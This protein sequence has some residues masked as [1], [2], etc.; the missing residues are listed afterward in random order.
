M[1][2][3]KSILLL[4]LLIL[5]Q[6]SN[7][8]DLIVYFSNEGF[9]V[10]A[11]ALAC[12]LI[13]A[14]KLN[15]KLYISPFFTEHADHLPIYIDDLVY[16]I[17][18]THSKY[19]TQKN[20][21]HSKSFNNNTCYNNIVYGFNDLDGNIKTQN[22]QYN[23]G[24]MIL[25][26]NKIFLPWDEFY[27][28]K[29]INSQSNLCIMMR[30]C[31]GTIPRWGPLNPSLPSIK[32]QELQLYY[33]NQIF[34]NDKPYWSVHIR[35][36]DKSSTLSFNLM[37]KKLLYIYNLVMKEHDKPGVFVAVETSDIRIQKLIK[38]LGFYMSYPWARGLKPWM[39]KQKKL[40][41]S[42]R[43]YAPLSRYDKFMLE[44][45]FLWAADK[46]FMN[47]GAGTSLSWTIKIARAY[48]LPPKETI[49]FDGTQ[50]LPEE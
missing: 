36:G 48:R 10:Q 29:I 42:Y 27:N 45:T 47:V 5:I 49:M 33:K 19:Y 22:F 18:T 15:R 34:P 32:Y 30:G 38:E 8:K 28:N 39:M 3:T 4:L 35:T 26:Q 1:Q 9:G 14:S 2:I 20:L 43:L 24:T 13:A 41:D 17:T 7:G 6:L 25:H 40:S 23:N 31:D 37:K 16:D 21:I 11:R 12:S 44:Y 46:C 50:K